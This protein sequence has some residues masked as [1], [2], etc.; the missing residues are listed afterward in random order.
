MSN[1]E[2]IAFNNL[3]E[4]MTVEVTSMAG[5]V[6]RGSVLAVTERD[7][8]IV[9]DDTGWDV[10]IGRDEFDRLVGE[11]PRMSFEYAVYVVARTKDEADKVMKAAHDG[12]PQGASFAYYP[13]SRHG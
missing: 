4:D 11:L 6:V 9:D 7:F 13:V 3:T 10:T 5:R 2:I 1:T 8:T 12:L